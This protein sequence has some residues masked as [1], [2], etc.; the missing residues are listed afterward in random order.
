MSLFL[1]HVLVTSF[2]A[3]LIWV[4]QLVHYPTFLFVS[5]ERF[6]DFEKFHQFRISLLVV[7]AM[8]LEVGTGVLLYVGSEYSENR[9]FL[10]SLF[11]LALI[12]LST[13]LW[14]GPDHQ[15]LEQGYQRMVILRLVRSN[16]IR[17]IAWSLRLF[18]LIL[19][20]KS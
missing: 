4:I 11:C 6:R 17:T 10:A 12:W 7:P 14:Q 20:L 13:L 18:F 1:A 5:E 3:G 8:L 15:R 2:L 16:W 9:F 19:I